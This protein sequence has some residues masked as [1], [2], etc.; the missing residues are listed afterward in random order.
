MVDAAI[1]RFEGMAA[2][3]TVEGPAIVESATTTVVLD[4]GAAAER[5]A[6]GSL[7]IRVERP[8]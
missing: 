8:A 2:G 1:V 6:S 7:S 3:D 4:P 5:T